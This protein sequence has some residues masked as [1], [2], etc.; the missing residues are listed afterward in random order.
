MTPARLL[1]RL[2]LLEEGEAP[3][4]LWS[5]LYFFLLFFGFYL[6]RP[7]REAIG[8][9]RGADK[10][11][12]LMTGTLLAMVLANPAFATLVSK[13]PRR[14]FIPLAYRFFA[15][16]ML[17][18]FL[19]FRFLPNH[20]G[21]ILG[22]GFYIWL[23]VFNLFV[24]SVFWGLMSD[25]WAEGQ[26]KRLF[27]FIAT[28]GTLGA[29]AGAA[30]TGVLTKGFVV[31]S[32]KVKVDPLSLLLVSALT[33]EAAVFCVKRLMAIFHVG[34]ETQ[35]TREPGP[36]PLEGLRLIATSRYLQLICLYIL[37]FTITSTLLYLQQGSIVERTFAG[38]A[39]RTAAFARIDLWVNVL[40]LVTQVLLTGRLITA[41][42]IPV[43]LSILPVLT[44]V[45]FGALWIWPTFAVMALI[46]VLRRGLH[47]ALDRPAREVLYI[48]LGPE[49]RYKAKPFIDTFIY[50]GGDLLGV[51]APTA[52]VALAIPV[53][54][55]SLGCSGLWWASSLALGRRVRLGG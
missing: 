32:F 25:V 26:G 10:L 47:Y 19:A 29:I 16:N 50:R 22:Y 6:V 4:L 21:A 11:P 51:W 41:L 54:L 43:V 2:V 37:L 45:G 9:A 14:R 40:T 38:T 34:E 42:G 48:P 31:A 39:A 49:E 23:S 3:G 55:A 17:A 30:L 18:L 24:V 27:G 20:G 53:G 46:Q 44:L 52:L 15:V 7:V 12:W 1:R 5:T 8:I 35:G 36:G 33:L 13:L 28:G